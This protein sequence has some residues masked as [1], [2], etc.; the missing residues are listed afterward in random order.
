MSARA[1]VIVCT[2]NRCESL[3]DILKALQQQELRDG[4]TID[5]IVVDNNSTDRTPEAIL[6]IARGGRWPL[7]YVF[8]PQQGLSRARNRGIREASGEIIAF[9]DDDVMPDPAWVQQLAAV[10]ETQR[11]DAAGGRIL[12]RWLA[13]PPAWLLQSRY[14][15]ELWD[16]LALLDGGPEV[17][18]ADGGSLNIIYGANMAF[19]KAV[20][21]E[22]GVFRTDLGQ[23][24]RLPRGEDTDM[25]GRLL[26]AGKRVVYTPHAVVH[27]MVGPERMRRGYFCRW[28]FHSGRSI[29]AWAPF[30]TPLVPKWLV[31]EWAAHGLRSVWAYLRGQRDLGLHL[32]LAFWYQL[33]QITETLRH[34]WLKTGI[35]WP[36]KW[37]EGAQP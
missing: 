13:S 2:Y 34:A 10:M 23:G 37:A 14:Q 11:A 17:A 24:A 28:K 5:I 8:E 12:P 20:F 16:A 4:A 18:V 33:G 19:R 36:A 29:A 25:V 30:A 35:A 31:R 21:A 9:T 26:K 32:E 15:K 27:H 1:S 3:R 7:R 6:E 22:V